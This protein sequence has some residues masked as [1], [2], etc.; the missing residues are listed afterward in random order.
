MDLI[1]V[2]NPLK[3]ERTTTRASVPTATP[4]TEIA[5]MLFT[6]FLLFDENK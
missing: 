2:S 1:R 6:A 4:S 5:V 3:T